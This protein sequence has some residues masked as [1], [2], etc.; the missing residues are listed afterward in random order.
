MIS[1][2]AKSAESTITVFFFPAGSRTPFSSVIGVG[3]KIKSVIDFG[4]GSSAFSAF[5]YSESICLLI[6]ASIALISSSPIPLAKIAD[7]NFGY[8]SCFPASS[9]SSLYHSFRTPEVW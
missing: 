6:V 1:R 7:F 4:S 5:S 3:A 8:G 2:T 9:K